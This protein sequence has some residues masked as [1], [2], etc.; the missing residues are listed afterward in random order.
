MCICV[1]IY[2]THCPFILCDLCP[3]DTMITRCAE[4][5]RL[6]SH[7]Q[8]S[9]GNPTGTRRCRLEPAVYSLNC[10]AC[11]L[12]KTLEPK[13]DKF[14]PV[15]NSAQDSSRACWDTHTDGNVSRDHSTD[16]DQDRNQNVLG[17]GVQRA[18]TGF[19]FLPS[20]GQVISS[21]EAGMRTRFLSH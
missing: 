18:Q 15:I 4:K 6:S 20:K 14:L 8:C 3:E 11:I 13:Q 1:Y 10:F 17:K 2:K 21:V 9:A 19:S 7:K 16:G 12:Q 5:R